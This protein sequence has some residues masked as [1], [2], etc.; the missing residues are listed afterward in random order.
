MRR[1]AVFRI[2]A[3]DHKSRCERVPIATSHL[4]GDNSSFRC[5]FLVIQYAQGV[6]IL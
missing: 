5:L 6:G 1:A 2:N 3:D 4:T